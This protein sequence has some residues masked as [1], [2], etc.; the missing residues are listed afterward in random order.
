MTGIM[1]RYVDLNDMRYGQQHKTLQ[2]S[3]MD[4]GV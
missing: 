3:N 4:K 2:I 1:D